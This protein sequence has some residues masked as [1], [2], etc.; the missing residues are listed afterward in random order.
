MCLFFSLGF[1]GLFIMYSSWF[2]FFFS[3]SYVAFCCCCSCLLFI[4]GEVVVFIIESSWRK[5]GNILFAPFSEVENPVS[6]FGHG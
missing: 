4:R 5:L 6:R 2:Y 3:S 1:L